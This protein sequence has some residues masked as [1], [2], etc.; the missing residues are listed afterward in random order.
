MREAS[1]ISTIIQQK[2]TG[3]FDGT[4]PLGAAVLSPA[5][6][7]RYPTEAAGG[8]FYW[9]GANEPMVINSVLVTLAT[10]N[11]SL[12]LVN[13]DAAGTPIVGE[14]FLVADGTGVDT[15]NLPTLGLV[16]LQSQALK[17]VTSTAAIAEVCGSIERM[18][19]R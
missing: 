8:L 10:G 1:D 11:V 2:A 16:I 3:A 17:L 12:S 13:L 19:R 15:L 7:Y 4:L 18:A 5:G 9:D 6:I 14:E